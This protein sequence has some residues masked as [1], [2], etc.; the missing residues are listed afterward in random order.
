MGRLGVFLD[1]PWNDGSTKFS[2]PFVG[3][4]NAAPNHTTSL[5]LKGD[6]GATI[7][8]T[9]VAATFKTSVVG[10]DFEIS[11][12]S[13]EEHRYTVQPSTK[14]ST[15]SLTI[16]YGLPADQGTPPSTEDV[17]V[18]STKAW[19]DYWSTS[20]FVDVLTGSTDPRAEELQRRIIL[21]RYLMRVNEAG[22]TPP[23]EVRRR[24]HG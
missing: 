24:I 20:G 2:A 12:D 16:N 10:N 13:A 14:S 9:M 19:E 7:L 4:W 5:Q 6:N 1:F 22:D 11:R 18:S 17:F 21:S 3:N 15:F 8:H 23:Q